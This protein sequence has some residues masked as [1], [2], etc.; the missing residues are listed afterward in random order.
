MV[1][2]APPRREAACGMLPPMRRW[3]PL[4]LLFAAP[5]FG[6]GDEPMARI[7]T[8]SLEYCLELAARLDALPGAQA[9]APRRLAEDGLRLCATGHARSGVAKLR[10]AIRAARY[11]G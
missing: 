11:G 6:A 3:F 2:A 4:A 7:T 8:D 9:D 10:R 1:I 5:S